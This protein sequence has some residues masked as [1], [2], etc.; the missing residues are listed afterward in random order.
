MFYH[1]HA[2]GITR[3]NVYAGEAAGY[4]LFGSASSL[5]LLY[6]SRL[7]AGAA[8]GNI[9]AAQAYMAD[10]T[11]PRE[12]TRSF[13]LLGAAFPS[14]PSKRGKTKTRAPFLSIVKYAGSRGWALYE[15]STGVNF[16]SRSVNVFSVTLF[17]SLS[18]ACTFSVLPTCLVFRSAEKPTN[19]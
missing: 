8:S 15:T 10:I 12:R 6:T 17:P 5:G 4:L 13:G 19:G 9:G 1:D 2:Y 11:Q 3:L 7:V 16:S 18:K 14:P